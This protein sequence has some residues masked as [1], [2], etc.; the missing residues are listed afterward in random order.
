MSKNR[1]KFYNKKNSSS[2]NP[3][4]K[5]SIVD[6][7]KS[8]DTT[9][10]FNDKGQSVKHTNSND[11][12]NTSETIPHASKINKMQID[13]ILNPANTDKMS[14]DGSFCNIVNNRANKEKTEEQSSTSNIR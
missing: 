7:T 9:S 10:Q 13:S 5:P 11:L 14:T 4:V 12:H 3:R 6:L 2:K 1:K 8:D